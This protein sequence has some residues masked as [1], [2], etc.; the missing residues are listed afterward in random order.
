MAA[1][2]LT[3]GKISYPGDND[4]GPAFNIDIGVDA[5]YFNTLSGTS[6]WTD[7]A[8]NPASQVFDWQR[9]IN[10]TTGGNLVEVILGWEAAEA[11]LNNATVRTALNQNN[12]RAGSLTLDP[13]AN[14]LGNY[15][16]VNWYVY[17]QEYIADDGSTQNLLNPKAALW[18]PNPSDF[19]GETIYGPVPELDAIFVGEY[20]SKMWPEQD[21]PS[22]WVLVASSVLPM[23]YEPG[24]WGM[25]IV[26]P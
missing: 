21:P 6:L 22:W 14:Y 5:S 2:M 11:F 16:N 18:M 24:S 9:M 8:S 15:A 4:G 13:A 17:S 23:A 10:A 1:Q 25:T 19:M 7:A 12:F 20:F 26:V 3:T